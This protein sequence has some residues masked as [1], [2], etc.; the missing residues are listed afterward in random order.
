MRE[1][2]SKKKNGLARKIKRKLT[3]RKS[4]KHPNESYYYTHHPLF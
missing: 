2:K 4:A 3:P 1:K